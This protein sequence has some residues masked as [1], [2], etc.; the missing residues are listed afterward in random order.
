M[1]KASG[2]IDLKSLKVAGES[3]TGYITDIDSNKGITIKPQDSSGND[4]LQMNSTAIEFFRNSTTTSVMRLTDNNFRLGLETANHTTIDINGL[5]IWTGTE[6]IAANAVAQF[7]STIRLGRNNGFR[8]EIDSDTF[9]ITNDSSP[10]AYIGYEQK[11]IVDTFVSNGETTTYTLSTTPREDGTVSPS[12][13]SVSR[14]GT[15]LTVN[16]GLPA[17]GESFT[18]SYIPN[19]AIP[20]YTMGVRNSDSGYG[21][22]SFAEGFDTEAQG[23][24]SHAEGSI[25]EA[26]GYSSHA[27]GYGTVASGGYSHAE[28]A[29]TAASG[30]YSHT[31]GYNTKTL[32]LGSHAEGRNAAASGLYSHAQGYGTKASGY[33][34]H[35]GG[36]GTI[37]AGEYSHAQGYYTTANGYCETTIGRYNILSNNTGQTSYN[38]TSSPYILVLG[39]GTSSSARSNALTV[40]WNGNINAN[41]FKLNNK[42]LIS[43]NTVSVTNGTWYYQQYATGIIEMWYSGTISSAFT[44]SNF[45]AY[46][47]SSQIIS[48]PDL[49]QTE[50]LFLTA[51]GILP[52]TGFVALGV[53]S[54]SSVT[55]W[56]YNRTQATT[57]Q[58][59][60]IYIH[61]VMR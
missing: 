17:V 56:P 49:G 24:Y 7:S 13:V 33:N 30:S 61:A 31:E 27:E 21:K 34:S 37:A 44:T 25:T 14:S 39:N 48:F 4:F 53:R 22:Y 9:M 40:D 36:C 20:Y 15:T 6:S 26:S 52:N 51:D 32:A 5:R 59:V 45:G 58:N 28:G 18:Y 46:R 50:I 35:A 2:S 41:G 29:L 60:P 11:T 8:T 3:A 12:S 1:T 42:D 57:A 54:T 19:T 23:S 10:F 55:I 16:S 47:G 38:T 43:Y